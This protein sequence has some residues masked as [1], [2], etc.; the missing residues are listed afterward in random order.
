MEIAKKIKADF[1]RT[2]FAITIFMSVLLLVTGFSVSVVA[3]EKDDVLVTGCI[4]AHNHLFGMTG[5]RSVFGGSH[6]YAASARNALDRMDALGIRTAIVM[7]PPFTEGQRD[8]FDAG[9]FRGAIA[10]YPGRFAFLGGGGTL[11]VMIHRSIRSG[12]IDG[13]VEKRFTEQAEKLTAMGI[14]GF[15]EMAAEHFSLHAHHPYETAPPDHPLFLLLADIAARHQLPI[16]LHME[17]IPQDMSSQGIVRLQEGRTPEHLKANI[18]AFERLLSHNRQARIIWAHAGWDNT[19]FR[20]VT[21]MDE[22]LARHPNLYMSIKIGRDSRDETRPLA[23]GRKLKPEWLALM[24]K[25]PDRFM[26]GSDIFFA[27]PTSELR[28]PPGRGE[29]VKEFLSQLPPEL[30][31]KVGL[32]NPTKIFNLKKGQ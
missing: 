24:T 25:Y 18:A 13:E 32:E 21:M 16:D 9:E 23:P 10:K 12:K 19:G 4:D 22:L 29:W 17:A 26:I 8:I 27:P 28:S 14:I 11:N 3:V 2:A 6:D 1:S 31:R 30:A 20:T 15:G 7:P 5:K